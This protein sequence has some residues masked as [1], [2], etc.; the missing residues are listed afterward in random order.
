M[1]VINVYEPAGGTEA[2][3][4][5]ARAPARSLSSNVFT[6]RKSGARPISFS[7]RHLGHH[8][9]YRVGS[10]LWHELNLYQTDDGRY[11]ADIRVFTK[12]QGSK[13]QFHVI[14][15]DSLEEALQF[16]E[17]HDARADV[18]AELALDDD[19]LSPAELLVQAAA[20]KARV[21]DAVSQYRAV[22]SAFL[23]EMNKH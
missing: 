8:N 7:G 10:P 3:S 2:I 14:V 17:S 15:A 18:P 9:G 22:L 6:L 11:V 21:A 13:D 12:A 19:T 16:L 1:N 4:A 5:A 23:S 20:L